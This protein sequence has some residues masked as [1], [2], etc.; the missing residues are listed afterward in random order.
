MRRLSLFISFIVICLLGNGQAVKA[1][2]NTTR[3]FP[4]TG[5]WV[6]GKFYEFYMDYKHA[7]IVFGSPITD[8]FL[9][10]L[11]DQI[12]QYFENARFELHPENPPGH[13]VVLT[14]LGNILYQPST[15]IVLNSFT[16]NCYQAM[17]WPFPVCFSFLDFYQVRGGRARF[18]KPISGMEYSHGRLTQHFEYAQMVW[19]P[20]HPKGAQVTLAPLGR[21]YFDIIQE[22]RSRL[23]PDRNPQY[24]MNI[25]ELDVRSFTRHAMTSRNET[26][27]LYVLV[28][29]Q[30]SASVIGA[31]VTLTVF[32]PN[33][34]VEVYSTVAT[35][36]LG[37]AEISFQVNSDHLGLAEMSISV[38]YGSLHEI[39]N[40][41]FRI[42]Y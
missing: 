14:E 2:N 20:D 9:D 31:R 34:T 37:L 26:Q 35:N 11:S 23:E 5:H 3:F 4:D 21:H 10:N 29:D 41:S 32:F 22:D 15:P 40:N 24:S 1:Q 6:T 36:D 16:P 27:T 13:Q 39:S 17:D 25:S 7:E 18:G 8:E 19:K 30:N 12:V 28:R 38:V 33:G 42:W